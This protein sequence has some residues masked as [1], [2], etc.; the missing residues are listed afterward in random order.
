MRKG[1]IDYKVEGKINMNPGNLWQIEQ[2]KHHAAFDVF[3]VWHI[4]HTPRGQSQPPV[5][6]HD[7]VFNIHINQRQADRRVGGGLGKP[8]RRHSVIEPHNLNWSTSNSKAIIAVVWLCQDE[9]ILKDLGRGHYST[10]HPCQDSPLL[11]SGMPQASH[12]VRGPRLCNSNLI[13]CAQ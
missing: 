5:I 10:A 4:A 9:Q 1:D 12:I 6:F 13:I 8:Q 11:G 7:N 2:S 3:L